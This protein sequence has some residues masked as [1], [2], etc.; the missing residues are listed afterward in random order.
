MQL[1]FVVLGTEINRWPLPHR[2]SEPVLAKHVCDRAHKFKQ[3][4][5]DGAMPR[6]EV[7]LIHWDAVLDGP[8]SFGR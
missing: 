3:R 8:F 5:P 6:C 1:I 2:H 4:F 7:R